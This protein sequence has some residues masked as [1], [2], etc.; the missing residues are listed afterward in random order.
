MSMIYGLH[1]HVLTA[2]LYKWN[3]DTQLISTGGWLWARWV[4][5]RVSETSCH[6]QEVTYAVVTPEVAFTGDTG[7]E[8]FSSPGFEDALA[9]KLLIIEATFLEEDIS[10]EHAKVTMSHE[11]GASTFILISIF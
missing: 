3:H 1:G 8:V 6:W 10:R 9:A 7:A 5:L 4:L 11:Y 2:A